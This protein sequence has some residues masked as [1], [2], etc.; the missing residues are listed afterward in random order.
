MKTAGI[1]GGLGPET[2]ANF[3]LEVIFSTFAESNYARPPLLIWSVPLPYQLED[4]FITKM[5]GE[6]RY[7]PFL[8]DA[9]E[10]LEQG[11]ADFLVIP[12]N[13]VH[14]FI[15]E[16][17]NAVSI[18]V[19]SIIDE[20]IIY[21]KNKDI[22]DVGV[23]ATSATIRKKL[24]EVKFSEDGISVHVPDEQDQSYMGD[25]INHLVHSQQN[26]KD[27]E[28][29]LRIIGK[30]PKEVETILLA[31]T[32]LQLLVPQNENIQIYDTMKILAEAT[33]REILS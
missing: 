2:T 24:Y 19:L 26:E 11:G 33:V 13:S 16:I 12:C 21:L 8:I 9:A 20:T 29:V 3:Y 30:F 32:D 1:I 17:R 5:R 31:C 28:K 10:R 25:I 22:K 14:I 18:P 6:E 15:N 7:L 23:L 27:K 4:D